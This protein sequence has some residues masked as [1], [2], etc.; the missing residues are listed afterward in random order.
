MNPVMPEDYEPIPILEIHGTND[1][2]VGYNDFKKV[3]WG[4]KEGFEN[5]LKVNTAMENFTNWGK[6]NRCR[7]QPVERIENDGDLV[8]LTYEKCA[9]KA[10]V[11]FVTLDSVGHH[12]Y[13]EESK[14]GIVYNMAEMIWD[15]LKGYTKKR[16]KN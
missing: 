4:V 12:P 9:K 10:K 1:G 3:F 13:H 6:F 2:A 8:E 11:S 16:R 14:Q 15:F 7:G 5:T